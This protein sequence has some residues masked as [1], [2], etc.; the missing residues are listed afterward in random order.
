MADHYKL[1]FTKDGQPEVNGKKINQDGTSGGSPFYSHHD[2]DNSLQFILD[3]NDKGL[4]V[5]V[6]NSNI[7]VSFTLDR[8]G[9]NYLQKHN[10]YITGGSSNGSKLGDIQVILDKDASASIQSSNLSMSESGNT[11]VVKGENG[12]AYF[13]ELAFSLPGA[14]I[15]G[16]KATD[17]SGGNQGTA[18]LRTKFEMRSAPYRESQLIE[19]GGR[20]EDLPRV[21]SRDNGFELG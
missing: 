3:M 8:D 11:I 4:D 14:E 2:P 17:Y 21:V 16:F 6:Y 19:G 13:N 7:S 15:S 18:E 5:T 12:S 1:S 9:L 10:G 20:P